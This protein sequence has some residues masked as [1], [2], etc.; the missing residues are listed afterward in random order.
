MRALG[1]ASALLVAFL[2]CERSDAPAP[3]PAP[4][5]STAPAPLPGVGA[6]ELGTAVGADGRVTAPAST[7]GASDTIH[8]SVRTEGLKAGST[9]SARWTYEDGQ[10]VSENR[11][12]LAANQA[13]TE[14]HISK[15]DGWPV[16][17][18]RVE[19]ALD[20]RPAGAREFEVR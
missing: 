16:G 8:A 3:A 2:G 18:Y 9:L 11:E 13:V 10:V 4:P 20:G 19:I 12:S 5:V 6:I 17:R 15:P 7:F 14:F 1:A